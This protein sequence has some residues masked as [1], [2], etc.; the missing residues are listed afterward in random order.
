MKQDYNSKTY[1]FN[2]G[3]R[4]MNRVLENKNKKDSRQINTP[5]LIVQGQSIHNGESVIK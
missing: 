2:I 3:I 4:L 1:S 5:T